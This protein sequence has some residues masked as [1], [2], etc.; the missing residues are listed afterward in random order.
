MFATTWRKKSILD[1]LETTEFSLAQTKIKRVAIIKFRMNK[2][3]SYCGCSFQIK[4]RPC[5][6]EVTN[7]IEAGFTEG[8]NLIV[9][10]QVRVDYE[11]DVWISLLWE[12]A[13]AC[14][15]CPFCVCVCTL[16]KTTTR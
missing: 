13:C 5:A 12:C 15:V 10:G 4:M 14:S 1:E 8:R 11:T 6:T 2:C 16:L 7:V 3:C 9:I